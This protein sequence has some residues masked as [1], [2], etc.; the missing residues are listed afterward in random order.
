MLLSIYNGRTRHTLFSSTTTHAESLVFQLLSNGIDLD[1]SVCTCDLPVLQWCRCAPPLHRAITHSNTAMVLVLLRHGASIMSRC[2]STG[3]NA[4]HHAIHTTDLNGGH[5]RIARDNDLAILQMLLSGGRLTH[6]ND[7]AALSARG[8]SWLNTAVRTCPRS[9]VTLV[10]PFLVRGL[11]VN[12][13]DAKMLT[14]LHIAVWN[15]RPDLAKM[16]LQRGAKHRGVDSRGR[17]PWSIACNRPNCE[18]IGI[19]LSRDAGLIGTAV[20][21]NGETAEVCLQRGLDRLL[22]SEQD[23]S[24]YRVREVRELTE[25]LEK[26]RKL[27]R[28]SRK[29]VG[30]RPVLQVYYFGM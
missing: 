21:E 3:D 19:L 7:A 28:L 24:E 8:E 5:F 30:V 13:A 27:A 6:M 10:M 29:L 4:V 22:A 25:M 16:L 11:D 17:T 14:P 20:N 26:L 9:S 12:V 15:N 18:L 2:T 23:E 1:A